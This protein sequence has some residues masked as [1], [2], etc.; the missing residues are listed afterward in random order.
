MWY[1]HGLEHMNLYTD[2]TLPNKCQTEEIKIYTD[3]NLL[4]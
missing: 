2:K 3:L 4:Y 1:I